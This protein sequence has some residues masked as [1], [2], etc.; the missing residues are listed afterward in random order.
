MTGEEAKSFAA[1]YVE[2]R[3]IIKKPIQEKEF[4]FDY[5]GDPDEAMLI[6]YYIDQ[7]I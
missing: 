7:M 4:L 5:K 6:W 2:V 1:K 3:K